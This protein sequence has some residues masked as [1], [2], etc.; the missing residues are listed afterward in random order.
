VITPEKLSPVRPGRLRTPE[1]E[2]YYR[3]AAVLYKKRVSVPL[4]LV[5]GIRSFGVAEGL[6]RAGTCDYV[7][8]SRPLICEPGLVKRWREGD[9]RPSECVS[10]NACFAPAS[11]GRGVY[12]V[13]M[14]KKRKKSGG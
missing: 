2:V 11:D 13:T 14:E 3:E 10:D 1:E 8:M 12:C 9:R 4:I 5:G 6:V 7:S